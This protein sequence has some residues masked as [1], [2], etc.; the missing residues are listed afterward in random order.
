MNTTVDANPSL[1]GYCLIEPLYQG[2]RTIVYR[3]KRLADQ[4]VV[5]LKLLQHEYPTFNELLQF[6]NQY[7]IAKNL[8]IPG[9]IRPYSL[10]AYG[11]SYALIMEDFGGVSLGEWMQQEE[12][13]NRKVGKWGIEE[14]ASGASSAPH[15]SSPSSHL[16]AVLAIALQLTNILHNLHQACVIHKDIKPANILIHPESKQVKLIDF[17]IA[18]LLP[19]E[20]QEIKN[21]NALEGTLAYLAPEQTGRMNRGIDYRADFYALGITLFELLTGQLPFRSTDPME[22]V[23]CHLAK[24]LPTVQSLCPTMPSVLSEIVSKLMAKNA[25]DRYQSALGLH[26]DLQTCLTQLNQT[27]EI[28][29]FEIGKRDVGDR[30]IIPEKLYGRE[31]E[32]QRLLEA[33]DRIAGNGWKADELDPDPPS[34]SSVSPSAA[35]LMLVAGFSGIGKTA[36]VNEIHKPIARQRGYFIKGK[37]DQFNRNIPFSGVV[38]ALRALIGQLLSES[39]TQLQTWKTQILT[40]LGENAQVMIEVIP[41]LERIIGK[42]SPAT[43]LSGSAAQNRFN[44]LF[45]KFI[46]VFTTPEHPLVMFLDDLQWADSASLN[47]IQVL[48]A[49]SAMGYL[50]MIG[51]YRDNEVF[52]AHPLMLTLDTVSKAGATVNTITLQPLSQTGLNHLVADTLHCSPVLAQPLSDLVMQKTQGNPFFATQ[53]LKA[54]HQDNLITFNQSSGYWQCDI[55][56][57]RDAALMDDVVEFMTLQLQKLPTTTQEM[58]KLAACIGAQFDLQTL[59]IVSDQPESEV[60][61]SLWK[62]LQEGLILPQSEVYKFFSNG[63]NGLEIDEADGQSGVYLSTSSVTESAAYKFLHDRVQQAAYSLIPEAQKQ[64]VHLQIGRLLLANSVVESDGQIFAIV[65]QLNHGL[66]LIEL[67]EREPIARLNLQAGKKANASTAYQAAVD[68]LL[69]SQQLL[70]LD[71]WESQY[72]LSLEISNQLAFAAYLSGDFERMQKTIDQ[73]RTQ[74]RS[75]LEQ[76]GVHEIEIQA[77]IVQGQPLAAVK[78]ALSFVEKFGVKFPIKPTTPQVLLGLA[79]TKIALLG[80]SPQTLEKQPIM[81]D[82]DKIAIVQVLSKT[83]SATYI[84]APDLMPLLVFRNVNIFAKHGNTNQSSFTYSFY[85]LILCGVLQDIETGYQF[86]ELALKLLTKFDSKE[87]QPRVIFMIHYFI[88]HWKRHLDG[89]LLPLQESYQSGLEIGDT[90]YAAWAGTTHCVNSYYAGKELSELSEKLKL[91]TES[92]IKINQESAERYCNIFDQTILCLLG[93]TETIALEGEVYCLSQRLSK[94]QENNDKTGLFFAYTNQALLGYLFADFTQARDSLQQARLFEDGGIA[95]PGL[96]VFYFYD[97]LACLAQFKLANRLEQRDRLKQLARNQKKMKLWADHA[98]MNYLHKYHLIEA[99]RHQNLDERERAIDLYDLAIAGAK[100]NGY[101]QEEALANELAAKFYLDWGK[102]KVAAGYMQEAYYCYAHWG[103][104]AKTDDLENCY[105]DLLRP[106]LQQAAQSLNI[107]ESLATIAA[108]SLSRHKS[109]NPSQFSSTNINDVLDFAAIFKTSQSLSEIIQLDELLDQLTQIIL[110]NS[111]GDRCALILPNE[112]DEWEVRAIAI[113]TKT[114]LCSEPLAGNPNIPIKLIQYVKNTQE[115]VI[116]D[117]LKTELPVIGDYLQ[118]HRPKSVLCLPILKQGHLAG[119]LYLKNRATSGVFTRDRIFILNFLCTQA[120]ISLENARL[121]QAIQQ[122]ETKFR[123][124]VEDVNDVIYAVTLDATFTYISPQ[125]KEMWGYEVDEFLHQSFVPLAHPDDLPTILADNQQIFDTGEKR[126]GL[127]FRTK[128]KDGSWFWVTCNNSPI[129]DEQ[130]QVIGLRGI[131]R[132]ISDHKATEAALRESEQRFRD[133]TEAAG[134]YI[135]EIDAKANYTYV[136]E[137]STQVKGYSPEQLLGRKP[138]EFMPPEDIEPVRAILL[139]AA[140]RKSS[141]TLQH[142]DILPTG[143]VVWEEVNGI[144]LLNDRGEIVGYRGT[145]LSITDRKAAEQA[146][147]R[148]Q[149]ERMHQQQTLRSILDSAPIWIWM[150]NTHGKILFINT[151][152]C[153]DVAIPESL[154]LAADHY[155]DVLGEAAINCVKSDQACLAQDAPFYFTET[156]QLADGQEHI[157]ETI[158]TPV[159]GE[160]GQIIGVIGLGIDVTQQRQMEAM[161]QEKNRS[162]SETLQ[163]LQQAQLRMI[164]GEKMS[165]LG[166]LV[167]GVAHEIN[168]PVGCIVGNVDAA[169]DYINDL[170]G[171]IDLYHEKFPQ[172]GAEIEDELETVDLDYVREDLPKLIRAMKDGGDRIK[173]ISKSL[174]TFSRADAD[175]KQLFNLHEG[176]E[177]TV[178]ILR[179]RL[180][181]NDQRPAIEVITNYGNIPNIECFPGQL[182]QVFM[183]ILANAIDALDESNQGRSFAEVQANP[184]RITIQTTLEDNQVK[185]MI[186]DNGPGM[187]EAVKDRIFDH[188]FTTKGVGKGTGLGLAIA[189]QIIVEKHGGAIVV[190]SEVDKGTE[191]IMTLP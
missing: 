56:Q 48:M 119:I 94:H 133:V 100:A 99:E 107:V 117:D 55:V 171:I 63:G 65:N 20:T 180:K 11:N 83:L 156:F 161:I 103:A 68:Y 73:V 145:G 60:A 102:E 75:L 88:F 183:N 129:K 32:V 40:T 179:H 149:V 132:N 54:L 143:E 34:G 159:K 91:Y 101:I 58:L 51:A 167:A 89:T 57:V 9:I 87:V 42:Q 41:E 92:F 82:G 157:L 172:P 114:E 163:E 30:F 95:S 152:F 62:A 140:A 173:A 10:E 188:L 122:S 165:A 127:E 78:T 66:T 153:T 170:L 166:N 19:K 169:Q 17:S 136:T 139:K 105:P 27:S 1:P 160:D 44:L 80:K 96:V 81:T 46:G 74:A 52:A 69:I 155:Q 144:P 116:I 123:A 26:H 131:A 4:Q 97:S 142:R 108:P 110:Q 22:L 187:P 90:E 77:S 35:E 141:F 84:A 29:T 16:T 21:P 14:P 175:M 137:K 178:L 85:A 18:S 15:S 39:D 147:Q 106:I 125:F 186:A 76:V 118:H 130:G 111:G 49:E 37:F 12:W 185:I 109:M 50:L 38:Q 126:S 164:Q 61:T 2:S 151:T 191:F 181:A 43:E 177:S 162:L 154:F 128:H 8:D 47:L 113:P 138:T 168:N 36:V 86:G 24:T 45:Q 148:S 104:K 79:E 176:I 134:E 146:L 182:N 7:T 174:R 53:F 121:Y 25:E 115:V 31:T 13:R 3:G 189:Q 158:K 33:F 190:N 93:N 135:W 112:H 28:V 64:A 72:S 98:P 59:A 5:I 124:F 23:H 6:R 71:S 120:A 150:V 67:T 184:N 70:N